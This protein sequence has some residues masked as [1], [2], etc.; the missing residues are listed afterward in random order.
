[1]CRSAKRAQEVLAVGA[2]D[3]P[4]QTLYVNLMLTT[5]VAGEHHSPLDSVTACKPT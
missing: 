1:M 2:S 4:F 5:A 3:E